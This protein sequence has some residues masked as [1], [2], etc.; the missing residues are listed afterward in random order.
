[1]NR[2]NRLSL[3]VLLLSTIAACA[4]PSDNP[5]DAGSESATSPADASERTDTSS[6]TSA[7][8]SDTAQQTEDSGG[9]MGDGGIMG[10]TGADAGD[11]G[12][13]E[14]AHQ[15]P[16]DGGT[17]VV[18]Y[19]SDPDPIAVGPF[20]MTLEVEPSSGELPEALDVAVSGWM[21]AHGHGMPTTPVVTSLGGGR[22]EVTNLRISMP[23]DWE[24][25]V[26]VSAGDAS[27]RAVFD[28]TIN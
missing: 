14:A 10:D 5:A 3:I 8:A 2:R 6:D 18:G 23:G 20:S 22:F 26:D 19:T 17:F 12:S 15:A 24:L 9:M 1:V 4:E 16:T 7:D 27:E 25:R 13:A 28:V 11:S 21:P